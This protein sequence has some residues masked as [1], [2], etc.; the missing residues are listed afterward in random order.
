MRARQ[1]THRLNV[2]SA[3]PLIDSSMAGAAALSRLGSGNGG[4]VA[5][6]VTKRHGLQFNGLGL[7]NT[8]LRPK[9]SPRT[10]RPLAAMWVH[11]R[12]LGFTKPFPP[13]SCYKVPLTPLRRRRTSFSSFSRSLPSRDQ[14]TSVATSCDVCSVICLS[15]CYS[16]SRIVPIVRVIDSLVY[17]R[18]RS[19]QFV[20]IVL[21]DFWLV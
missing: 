11:D 8:T 20:R 4:G 1:V 5:G 14:G 6:T 12:I 9:K 13:V 16:C 17:F 21:Q 2:R 18:S 3:A 7:H 10:K 15:I 19:I